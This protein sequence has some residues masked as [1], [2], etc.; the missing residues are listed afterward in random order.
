MSAVR[1]SPVLSADQLPCHTW[2]RL[3][4]GGHDS[5]HASP[6]DLL[7]NLN[8]WMWKRQ[9]WGS[10]AI[11]GSR[12][13]GDSWILIVPLFPGA[14]G[15]A[16]AGAAARNRSERPHKNAARTEAVRMSPPA[17]PFLLGPVAR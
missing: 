16:D 12:S 8:P 15:S 1:H 14:F 6:V 13:P 11:A 17:F 3:P 5:I 9:T 10:F 2:V 4:V 7:S